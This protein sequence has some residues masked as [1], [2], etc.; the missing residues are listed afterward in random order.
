MYVFDHSN[1]NKS[2][3]LSKTIV[4]DCCSDDYLKLWPWIFKIFFTYTIVVVSK[5][6]AEN[7]ILKKKPRRKWKSPSL[8]STIFKITCETWTEPVYF[9]FRWKSLEG[10]WPTESI[11]LKKLTVIFNVFGATFRK[12]RHPSNVRAHKD[13]LPSVASNVK[14]AQHSLPPLSSQ[15]NIIVKTVRSIAVLTLGIIKKT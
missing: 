6:I 11:M 2:R 14:I 3:M 4:V 13:L 8:G 7:E 12:I 10:L 5:P 9:P 15:R 1:L